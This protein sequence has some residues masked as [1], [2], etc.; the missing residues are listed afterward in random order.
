ML[1]FSFIMMFLIPLGIAFLLLMPKKKTEQE[2][3]N[4]A[5]KQISDEY[6]SAKDLPT[7]LPRLP[8]GNNPINN[9][10]VVPTLKKWETSQFTTEYAIYDK[11]ND[12]IIVQVYSQGCVGAYY[13]L[14]EFET[15]YAGEWTDHLEYLNEDKY[16]W[17][18]LI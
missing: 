14:S 11:I 3:L 12:R 13:M 6:F 17:L 9:S 1:I 16:E 7:D 4:Q 15:L 8:V 10:I 5:L 18:G 2:M